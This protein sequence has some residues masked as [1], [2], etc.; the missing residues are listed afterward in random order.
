MHWLIAISILIL[1]LPN[2]TCLPPHNP[3]AVSKDGNNLK[4]HVQRKD[5]YTITQVRITFVATNDA[6]FNK[7]Y[8]LILLDATQKNTLHPISTSNL[9]IWVWIL[10]FSFLFSASAY[11]TNFLPLFSSLLCKT[12][13]KQIFKTHIKINAIATNMSV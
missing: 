3:I 5:S 6:C 11:I 4:N 1:I 13:P 7:K 12:S 9:K 8:S 10:E 2:S